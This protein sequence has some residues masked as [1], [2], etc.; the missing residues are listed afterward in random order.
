[1]TATA[2]LVAD[3]R[4]RGIDEVSARRLLLMAFASECLDRMQEG[5]ARTHVEKL[6]HA[7]LVYIAQSS[8]GFAR[9]THQ[10]EAERNLE[11]VG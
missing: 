5:P 10:H 1:M 3:L 7:H 11:E 2:A 4:S 6:I 9:A 8:A